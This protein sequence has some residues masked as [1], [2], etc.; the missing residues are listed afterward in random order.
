MTYVTLLFSVV[1][2]TFFLWY[3]AVC[4]LLWREYTEEARLRPGFD[5]APDAWVERLGALLV[6]ALICFMVTALN[7]ASV[8]SDPKGYWENIG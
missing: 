6:V 3:A 1:A 4:I 5:D 2:T 7:V 8:M